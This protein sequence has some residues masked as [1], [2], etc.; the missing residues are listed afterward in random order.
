MSHPSKTNTRNPVHLAARSYDVPVKGGMVRVRLA[1]GDYVLS[2]EEV[3]DWVRRCALAVNSYYGE[4]PV[5]RLNLNI[6]NGRGNSVRGGVTYQYQPPFIN[7]MVG[8]FATPETLLD[9]W[10]LT[11]EMTHLGFPTVDDNHD[12]MEEGMAT[13][14][15]PWERMR[16]GIQSRED[17]WRELVTNLPK[18]QPGNG[19]QGLSNTKTW[20]RTYWG[21]ALFYFVADV[22][23]R[24]Q[25]RNKYGLEDAMR[26]IVAKGGTIPYDWEPIQI[27]EAADKTL[28]LHVMTKLYQQM[29]S[30]PVEVD[31]NAMWKQLG[32]VVDGNGQV[33]FNDRAP[34]AAVRRGIEKKS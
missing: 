7:I 4:F 3:L 17:V 25:S 28:G 5:K 32:V 21:G 23:I 9:D 24:K 8:A 10:V 14:I 19:D 15:E 34:L 13:Y 1:E 2:D 22:E 6:R 18:G 16:V 29:S 27:C 30:K 20:G 26:A 33:S 12:W 11:H 31:L